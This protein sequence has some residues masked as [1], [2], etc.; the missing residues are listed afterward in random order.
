MCDRGGEISSER[1]LK[2]ARIY[3][4]SPLRIHGRAHARALASGKLLPCLVLP[5][6]PVAT[7][8]GRGAEEGHR[9]ANGPA[10]AVVSLNPMLNDSTGSLKKGLPR[11]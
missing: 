11:F 2:Y 10:N 3:T 1:L 8:G 6:N 9:T 4:Q 5:I 7:E